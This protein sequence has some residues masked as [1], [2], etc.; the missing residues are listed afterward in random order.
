MIATAMANHPNRGHG[1]KPGRT[2][3]P[4]EI[5]Q[6]REAAGLTQTEAAHLVHAGLRSWQQW[7]SEIEGDSRRMHPG[8]LELF[9]AKVTHPELFDVQRHFPE[10]YRTLLAAKTARMG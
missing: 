1:D 8:L 5:R 7:E 3:K 6:A 10:I 4:A 9:R 2:P